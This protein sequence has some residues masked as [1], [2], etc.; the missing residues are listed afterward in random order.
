MLRQIGSAMSKDRRFRRI[1]FVSIAVILGVLLG[2]FFKASNRS[3]PAWLLSELA[4][5][6]DVHVEVLNSWTSDAL[7]N[8]DRAVHFQVKTGEW[9]PGANTGFRQV[10]EPWAGQV[11]EELT[12]TTGWSKI[13]R[14]ESILERGGWR[15]AF[16]LMKI[17]SSG[18]PEYVGFLVRE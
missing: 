14:I 1:L 5:P 12:R 3:V 9:S 17:T 4:I 10:S 7:T 8:S 15:R 18:D 11:A 16:Y 13:G 6:D 2:A